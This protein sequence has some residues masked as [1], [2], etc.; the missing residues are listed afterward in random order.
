MTEVPQ[1][2]DS[3]LAV[4][5]RIATLTLDRDDVRNALTGTALVDDIVATVEWANRARE[6]SVLVVTGAGAAFS[7]GGNVKDMRRRA[8]EFSGPVG[9]IEE[10][11]RRGIQRLPLTLARAEVPVI[12]AVNGPAIGAGCD[13]ACMCDLRIGSE[14]AA[15]GETFVNLGLIPGDGGAWFVQ[16]LIGTARAAE[17]TFT[18]R[19]VKAAEALEWGLLN[20]LV[21]PEALRARANEIAAAIAAKPPQA[22]RYAKRLLKI[23]QRT[24]LADFLDLCA[25]IQ[26]ICHG[27]DD[28][29]EA[30]AAFLDKRAPRLGGR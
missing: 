15:F 18:G 21:A 8:R 29:V 11:Y 7:S 20:E 30:V 2:T 4:D 12:A 25:V 22:L 23:A 9:D 19:V 14:R 26:G 16:R 13:L 24:E 27:T 17:M 6:V 1:P 10:R 28:H 3:I 5:G